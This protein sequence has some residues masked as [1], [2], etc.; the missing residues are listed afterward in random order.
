[1]RTGYEYDGIT[2]ELVA[3]FDPNDRAATQVSYAYD[4]WRNIT[5]IRFPDGSSIAHGYDEHGRR[6]TTSDVAGNT[7]RTSTT[8]RACSPGPYNTPRPGR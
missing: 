6:S 4:A 1:V 8:R 7:T 3:V 5:S 2:G